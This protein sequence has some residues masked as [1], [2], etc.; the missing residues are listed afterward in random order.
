MRPA[1][2]KAIAETV[3]EG[4]P[5]LKVSEHSTGHGQTCAVTTC[6][7]SLNL[8]DLRQFFKVEISLH[9][10][11]MVFFSQFLFDV[12]LLSRVTLFSYI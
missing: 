4:L 10:R 11:N 6:Q 7:N 12:V 9:S 1:G 5:I 8:H 2:A 3:S